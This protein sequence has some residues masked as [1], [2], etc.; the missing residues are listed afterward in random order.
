MQ[1]FS[2]LVLIALLG[3]CS[4]PET[5]VSTGAS[6]PSLIVQGAPADSTLYVDGLAMGPAGQFDGKPKVLTVLE[7]VHK[8]EIRVGTTVVY[9]EKAFVSN[10]EVHTVRVAGGGSQ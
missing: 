9:G 10:G 5:R 4:L 6:Q 7:G 2:V 8:V 3:A 1:R